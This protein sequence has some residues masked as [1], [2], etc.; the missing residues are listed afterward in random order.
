MRTKRPGQPLGYQN[1]QVK[2]ELRRPSAA[3]VAR[4]ATVGGAAQL[5]P[6]AA[7]SLQRAIGN[8][9]FAQLVG[10]EQ[11]QHGAGCGHQETVQRSAADDVS[12][13]VRSGGSQLDSS[14]QQDMEARFGGEDFSDVRI[15]TGSSAQRSAEAVGAEAYTTGTNHIVFRSAVNKKTLA[16]ELEHVRQQ[17]AGTV[18]GT[19]NG[20]GLKVSDP[21]DR[22]E[23][24]AERKAEQVMGA[25]AVQR[26]TAGG[27]SH[28]SGHPA[29]DAAHAIQRMPPKSK[30]G[31]KAKGK[32]VAA[33]EEESSSS[34]PP[35]PASAYEQILAHFAH[36]A[37][38]FTS[39]EGNARTIILDDGLGISEETADG[40]LEV[41]LSG[42][43]DDDVKE[44]IANFGEF[45]GQGGA[46]SDWGV[47]AVTKSAGIHK[48][49]GMPWGKEGTL[50]HKIPRNI[51]VE[52]DAKAEADK[53]AAAPYYAFLEELREYFN[54]DKNAKGSKLL[55]SMPANLELGPLAEH[56]SDDPGPGM[57]LNS[58][59]GRLTPRSHELN[60]AN[61]IAGASAL[62]WEAFVGRLR[63]AHLIQVARGEMVSP[64]DSDRWKQE[65][66]KWQK[67][68]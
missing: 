13:V 17:R 3:T 5:S 36:A 43:Y 11:H 15:H 28:A 44:G 62:D 52:I 20:S 2:A 6:S 65:K 51:L 21:S 38:G 32:K 56:R 53:V 19:D 41:V 59:D 26:S 37:E 48:K 66:G 34:Q 25:G 16:H 49:N 24:S 7:I 12:S 64:P 68:N 42:D 33:Q 39:L 10:Q 27:H 54:T 57:D 30:G 35:A 4:M 58:N 67:N 29:A 9:A 14:T 31:T 40:L 45:A 8:A 47:S 46:S 55:Q 50:H 18:A 60:E 1:D 22:F 61:R 63:A 23:T